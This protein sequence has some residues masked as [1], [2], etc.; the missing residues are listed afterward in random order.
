MTHSPS[1]EGKR[2]K[3]ARQQDK[4]TKNIVSLNV[5]VTEV[6]HSPSIERKR[7]VKILWEKRR[8][9]KRED[10]KECEESYVRSTKVSR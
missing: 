4:T 9:R 1:I 5:I 3:T 8:S 6:T 2:K 10:K 7:L